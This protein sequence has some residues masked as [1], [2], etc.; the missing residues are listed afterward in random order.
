MK[1]R[2]IF[3]NFFI[4]PKTSS[5]P[6][7]DS[8]SVPIILLTIAAIVPFLPQS[9]HQSLVP[10]LV[11][12]AFSFNPRNPRPRHH[13]SHLTM[14]TPTITPEEKPPHKIRAGFLGCG[15]IASSIA[16]SLAKPDHQT[17]LAQNSLA[18]TSIH[19]TRRSESKSNALKERFPDVV[20][21]CE[22]AEEVV[23]N[24]D[25]V[26]LCVLPQHVEGVLEELKE[27]G[28]WRKGEH[29]LVSLVVSLVFLSLDAL[30]RLDLLPCL[31]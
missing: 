11:A 22:T 16:T 18:L 4:S 26:F 19:V 1:R 31:F 8:L 12:N 25:L 10:N 20:T 2:P 27:K 9:K 17:H 29:T 6:S 30:I 7:K 14:S 13:P 28:V 23:R 24:S 5:R 15:T 21:V 3:F